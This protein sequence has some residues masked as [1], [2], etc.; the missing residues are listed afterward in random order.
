MKVKELYDAVALLGFENEI[1]EE[2]TFYPALNTALHDIFRMIPIKRRGLLAHYPPNALVADTDK[3][4]HSD[5]ALSFKAE[6]A[7]AYYIE[8]SGKGEIKFADESG[9]GINGVPDVDFEKIYGYR[10]IRGFCRKIDGDFPS[11]LCITINAKTLCKVKAIA[12]YGDMASDK[13]DDIP[14]PNKYVIYNL[15]KIIPDLSM[16]SARPKWEG[17]NTLTDFFLEDNML[18]VPREHKGDIELTYTPKIESY[19][20]NDKD[21]DIDLPDEYIGALKLLIASYVWLDDN[22]DRAQ[23]YKKLYNEEIALISAKHRDLNPIKYES[24]NNW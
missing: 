24:V 23:Y 17:G 22:E 19:T 3:V 9:K 8:I 7:R 15:E 2:A 11:E 18:S 20:V 12:I 21:E 5:G 6:G 1:D 4:I 16:L 13:A 10:M 14:I